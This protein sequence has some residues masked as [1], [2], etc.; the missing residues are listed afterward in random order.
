MNCFRFNCFSVVVFLI[1]LIDPQQYD[2]CLGPL[3]QRFLLLE[4]HKSLSD[5]KSYSIGVSYTPIC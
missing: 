3:F 2:P 5:H 4:Y 1:C